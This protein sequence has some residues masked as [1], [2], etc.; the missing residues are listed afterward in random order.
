[1]SSPLDSM[2]L[3]PCFSRNVKYSDT[4]MFSGISAEEVIITLVPSVSAERKSTISSRLDPVKSLFF[5][6]CKI[7]RYINALRYL[8]GGSNNYFGSFSKRGEKI[9]YIINTVFLDFFPRYRRICPADSCKQ[10]S[11][12][13]IYFR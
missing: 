3:N 2:R 1:M 5:K 6:E 9:N 4:L 12:I 10:K 7:F 13:I 11:Q 8:C